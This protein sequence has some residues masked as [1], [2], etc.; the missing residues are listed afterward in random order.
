MIERKTE[1]KYFDVLIENAYCQSLKTINMG[2]WNKL[3][4]STFINT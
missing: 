2:N 4:H 3:R 1:V